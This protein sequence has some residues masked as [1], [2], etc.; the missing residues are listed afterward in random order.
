MKKAKS[1][2]ILVVDDKPD[3]LRTL[4]D[5]M[6]RM[7]LNIQALQETDARNAFEIAQLEVPDLIITDWEMP[8]MNGIEF[9]EALQISK[10]TREIPVIMCTGIMT[11]SLNL[12]TALDAGAVDYIRKPV[13]PLEFQARVL[14]MLQL[15]DSFKTIQQQ[16]KQLESQKQE[17]AQEKLKSDHLLENILPKEIAKELKLNGVAKPR[18]FDSVTVM[19]TDFVGFT[20]YAEGTSPE[21][22]VQELNACFCAFDEIVLRHGV[23]KIKTIGD[24]YMCAGGLPVSNDSHPF[25][26]YKAAKEIVDFMEIR[27]KQHI[28]NGTDY[29]NLRIG[30]HTGPIIAGTVGI[31]KFQYD[32]W[33]DTVNLASR[34]ES[35]GE[36]G[37]INISESTYLLI[38]EKVNCSYRGEIDVKGK[39]KQKMYFTD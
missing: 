15:G 27:K 12:K 2:K 1:Y 16:M 35:N 13:D 39:G 25:D 10:Y 7:H 24:A 33:G 22:L 18:S 9:I 4:V 20:S 14:S 19:F 36:A 28:E 34:I 6:E 8:D 37:K 3:N 21:E 23:E 31:N 5:Q 38:K 11:S 17:I 32:I 29:L 26:V 30:I